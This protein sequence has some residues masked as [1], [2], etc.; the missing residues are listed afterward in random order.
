MTNSAA[1]APLTP[2]RVGSAEAF[3]SRA[4]DIVNAALAKT[5]ADNERGLAWARIA[6][7]AMFALRQALL[8]GD[9]IVALRPKDTIIFV[10]LWVAIA[11]SAAYLA[12][13][14]TRRGEAV[15]RRWQFTFAVV[16]VALF[17]FSTIPVVLWPEPDYRGILLTPFIGVGTLVNVGAGM[18]LHRGYAVG[19]TVAT[20][21]LFF[22]VCVLDDAIWGARAVWNAGYVVFFA[23]E[24]GGA[25]IVAV[26]V[27]TRT[28]DLAA[29]SA[30]KAIEAERARER[31][32]AYVGR[33]VAEEALRVDE[34]VIGG[35]RQ[36]VAVLF[37]DLR[38]FTAYSE[39]LPPEQLVQQLNAYLEEMVA[40]ITR[41]GGVVDKYMGDGIMAVFG[42][43][44]SKGDDARRALCAAR[45]MHIALAGHNRRRTE[46]GMQA[47]KMGVGVHYGAAVAG[48]VGTLEHAQYT[49]IGDVVN[50]AAR[51]ESATKDH[52]VEVLFS[53]DLIDAAATDVAVRA[54]GT[55]SVRGRNQA[56]EVFTLQ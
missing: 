11:I 16:D 38:G 6:V 37:S 33:E 42:A 36:P 30:E 18:R 31:L 1:P 43:P 50:L 51:L 52:D 55:I 27:A 19:V 20:M 26:L 54:V 39:N 34:I 3:A 24:M 4:I 41:H 22:F 44:R 56:I 40:V 47:L 14:A 49:I 45:D 48:N 32:G 25:G 9:E 5:A 17:G 13:P 28:L 53:K 46:R 2:A 8:F 7:C 12:R 35:V 23:I 29:R 15:P 21:C 10:A